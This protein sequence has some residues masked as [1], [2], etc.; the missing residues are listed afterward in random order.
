MV[1][2]DFEAQ[3]SLIAVSQSQELQ[4][5]V[6]DFRQSG[7]KETDEKISS[8]LGW[9]VHIREMLDSN[10]RRHHY[11]CLVARQRE[12]NYGTHVKS[13]VDH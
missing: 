2:L 8:S 11:N 10:C 9:M 6:R 5:A 7:P 1:P 13:Q 3:K 12:K 4:E